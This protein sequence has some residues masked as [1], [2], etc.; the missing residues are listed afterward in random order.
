M[1][2][3]YLKSLKVVWTETSNENFFY[4]KL[5]TTLFILIVTMLIFS[6][7]SQ[8]IETREGI[9]YIDPILSKITAYDLSWPIFSLIYGA[10]LSA[11]IILLYNPKR[12]ILIFA[13]YTFMVIIRGIMMFLLPLNP[14]EGMI[15]L[16]DPFVS[17]FVTGKILTRDLFFSGHTATMFLLF[18]VIPKK[19]KKI[20]L[21]VT[22]LVAVGVLFQKVHY[23]IDVLVAPFVS[24]MV[25]RWSCYLFL[26]GRFC[27]RSY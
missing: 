1:P 14:P 18:L 13:A 17:L 8:F 15:L 2:T 16:Q 5:F 20:F 25:Y 27:K 22:M 3:D 6:K 9:Q 4:F 10:I 24:Y 11:L 12:L 26:Q 23:T 19:F 21:L 7:F